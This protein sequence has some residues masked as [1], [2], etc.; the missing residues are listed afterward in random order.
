MKLYLEL[1]RVGSGEPVIGYQVGYL[2]QTTDG[3][4]VLIDT[5]YRPESGTWVCHFMHSRLRSLRTAE[6]I[7]VKGVLPKPNT[8]PW[9]G[10]PI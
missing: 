8:K 5:G 4:T 10:L 2:V 7:S 6:G 3:K 1:G 9:R